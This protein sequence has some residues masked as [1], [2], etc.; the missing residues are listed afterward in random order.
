MTF[1]INATNYSTVKLQNEAPH[2]GDSF[3]HPDSLLSSSHEGGG[4]PSIISEEEFCQFNKKK[5]LGNSVQSFSVAC[6]LL[7]VKQMRMFWAQ[8]RLW[9]R[10]VSISNPLVW[11]TS[12]GLGGVYMLWTPPTLLQILPYPHHMA[13]IHVIHAMQG[14]RVGRSDMSVMCVCGGPLVFSKKWKCSFDP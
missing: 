11:T 3:P 6:T 10:P 14:G 5:S 12:L 1:I 13:C 9:W 7:K 2:F 8:Q 4:I